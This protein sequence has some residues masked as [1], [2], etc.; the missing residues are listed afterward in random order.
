MTHK[1]GFPFLKCQMLSQ[2]IYHKKRFLGVFKTKLYWYSYIYI[3]HKLNFLLNTKTA[4]P[5]CAMKVIWTISVCTIVQLLYLYKNYRVHH[6]KKNYM[7]T[8]YFFLPRITKESLWK[9][10]KPSIVILFCLL[11]SISRT[12]T[13][14]HHTYC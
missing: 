3:H 13:D 10:Q 11:E 12:K 7:L 1:I 2:K 6:E 4:K 9:A 5:S 8:K 14:G